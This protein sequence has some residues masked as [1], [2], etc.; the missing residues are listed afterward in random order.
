MSSGTALSGAG[1]GSPVMA[2]RS[3][4]RSLS[5][6]FARAPFDQ[7]VALVDE[8]LHARAAHDIELRRQKA[9]RGAGLA[10]RRAHQCCATSCLRDSRRFTPDLGLRLLPGAWSGSM[11]TRREFTLAQ[12]QGSG[13]HQQTAAI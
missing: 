5:E 3:P 1:C 7:H 11:A 12:N 13:E 8:E 2:M 4:P 6:G 9:G 10:P